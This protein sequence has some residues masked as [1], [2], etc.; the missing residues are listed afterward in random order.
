M[1]D[2]HFPV[3]TLTFE[4]SARKRLLYSEAEKEEKG[5]CHSSG[6]AE[7]VFFVS[8][9]DTFIAASFWV[10]VTLCVV[11]FQGAETR[12]RSP[13]LSSQF[14]RSLELLMRTLSVCQPF[15]VRCI[16]PNEYKKPMVSSPLCFFRSS[17]SLF[18]RIRLIISAVEGQNSSAV[19]GSQ[20]QHSL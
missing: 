13:T 19:R 14:K 6:R 11:C 2:C 18:D 20:T 17:V 12:K 16:K 9:P 1:I 10:H 3:Y 15:F 7:R 5:L 4:L 8:D